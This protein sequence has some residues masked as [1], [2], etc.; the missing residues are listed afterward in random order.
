MNNTQRLKFIEDK[1]TAAL[2][3]ETLEVVDDSAE[4]EG[5]AGNGGGGH[6]SVTVVAKA[7]VG[8]SAIERHK[9]I[10][11][12]LGAAVGGEIHAL[13]ITAKVPV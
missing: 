9:M 11:A 2:Q 10:Y 8:C 1:L 13:R 6:F 5:H 7:F 4:H 12:A 3:P